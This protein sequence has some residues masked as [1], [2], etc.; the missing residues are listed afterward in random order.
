[1]K[2]SILPVMPM[3]EGCGG[4]LKVFSRHLLH[5][6]IFFLLPYASHCQNVV[7]NVSGKALVNGQTAELVKTIEEKT[8]ENLLHL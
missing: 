3:K 1:M 2:R 4:Y 8:A 5:L 6:L 7:L